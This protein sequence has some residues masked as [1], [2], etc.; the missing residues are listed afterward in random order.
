MTLSHRRIAEST[1]G[2]TLFCVL[3]FSVGA[4][5]DVSFQE[6]RLERRIRDQLDPGGVQSCSQDSLQRC[7]P[8]VAGDT[9]GV[10]QRLHLSRGAAG[11]TSNC[12]SGT[13]HSFDPIVKKRSHHENPWFIPLMTFALIRQ[14]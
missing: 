2:A 10:V 7:F 13:L 4:T 5:F 3:V 12:S 6:S 1:G 11:P 8:T 14:L 9:S